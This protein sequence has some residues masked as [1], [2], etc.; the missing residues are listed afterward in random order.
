MFKIIYDNVGQ[1]RCV[2]KCKTNNNAEFLQT[3]H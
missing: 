3:G 2:T 1:N